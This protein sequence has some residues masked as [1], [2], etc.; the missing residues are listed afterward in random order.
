MIIFGLL[1][2]ANVRQAQRQIRAIA[3]GGYTHRKDR[4]LLH[5]LLLQVMVNV[6]FSIPPATY[7]VKISFILSIRK[8]R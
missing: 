8:T 4:H 1:T 3:V 2:I 6:I 5:M 7:Q